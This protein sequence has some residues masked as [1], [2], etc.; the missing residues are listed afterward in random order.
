LSD[1]PL[2]EKLLLI[3][4]TIDARYEVI[5]AQIIIYSKGCM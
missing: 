2:F 1:E 4:K 3:C 5:D